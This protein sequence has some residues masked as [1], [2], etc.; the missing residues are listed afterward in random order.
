MPTKAKKQKKAKE[1]G[2][3]EKT[4]A[5]LFGFAASFNDSTVYF[6]DLQQLPVCLEEKTHFLRERANYSGQLKSFLQVLGE[7]HPTCVVVCDKDRKKAVRKFE[8][9]KKKYTEKGNYIVKTLGEN[10][11]RFQSIAVD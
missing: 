9:M 10:A 5:F 4:D 3:T 8:K 1:P 2:K 6:T 11:F 7:A